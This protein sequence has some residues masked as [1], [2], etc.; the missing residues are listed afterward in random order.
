MK[1]YFGVM[2][3]AALLCLSTSLFAQNT[4]T[5]KNTYEQEAI[6]MNQGLFRYSYVKNGVKMPVGVFGRKLKKEFLAYPEAMKEYK[7]Y[8]KK[9]IIGSMTLLCSF[10][11]AEIM[12][13]MENNKVANNHNSESISDGQIAG[14]ASSAVLF[15][16]SLPIAVSSQNSLQKAIFLRNSALTNK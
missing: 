4:T 9:Q 2:L 3:F 7:K 12:I 10:A 13:L 8:Q 11:I 15:Y 6:Y 16:S 14:L 1:N 5:A